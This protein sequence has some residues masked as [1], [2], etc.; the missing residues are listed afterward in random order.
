MT[1][2]QLGCCSDEPPLNRARPLFP[3]ARSVSGPQ[4]GSEYLRLEIFSYLYQERVEDQ[5][6]KDLHPATQRRSCR[7]VSNVEF[8]V[9]L[10]FGKFYQEKYFVWASG[11]AG[12]PKMQQ[13]R[14]QL[15]HKASGEQLD[16]HVQLLYTQIEVDGPYEILMLSTNLHGKPTCSEKMFK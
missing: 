11:Q 6:Q 15:E 14:A 4:N 9:V 10:D 12:N 5:Y 1:P 7:P 13:E 8:S 3:G 16:K 2:V